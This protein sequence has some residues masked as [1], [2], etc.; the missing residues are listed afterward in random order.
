V[1]TV[2]LKFQT[3]CEHDVAGYQLLESHA[4]CCSQWTKYEHVEAA[5]NT[6]LIERIAAAGLV[7]TV[8][9]ALCGHYLAGHQLLEWQ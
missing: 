6:R 5:S 4:R 2:C 3:L 9:S 8:L 1:L 7:L